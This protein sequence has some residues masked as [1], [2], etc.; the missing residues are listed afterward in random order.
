M[1]ITITQ[2]SRAEIDTILHLNKLLREKDFKEVAEGTRAYPKMDPRGDQNVC[3]A[4][5]RSIGL[6]RCCNVVIDMHTSKMTMEP[7]LPDRD[8]AVVLR[9]HERCYP[10]NLL[11]DLDGRRRGPRREE[12]GL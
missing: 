1:P 12:E 10:K 7:A 9:Y 4:C 11:E 3:D 5:Q 6:T 2:L 8:G